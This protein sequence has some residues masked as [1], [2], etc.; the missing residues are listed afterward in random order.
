[1]QG[2][3]V[4]LFATGAVA[5]E[6]GEVWIDAVALETQTGEIPE[7]TVSIPFTTQAVAVLEWV[8][9]AGAVYQPWASANLQAWTPLP[10]VIGSGGV[11]TAAEPLTE[12]RVFFRLGYP[13]QSTPDPDATLVPLFHATTEREPEVLEDTGTALVT[14]LADRARDRHAREDI[15]NGAVFRSYD[16]YLPFYWEQR[17]AEIEIEDRVAKGGDGVTFRFMTHAQ[18]NPAEFR[19]FYGNTPSV[20]LY[21]TNLSDLPGQG[22]TLTE[23]RPSTRY[24][25]ETE[26]HYEATLDTQAPEGRPLEVGDRIEIELSQFLLSPRNGRPNYYGTAFLYVVGQGVVPW[27]AKFREEAPDPAAREA[28]SFDSHPLPEKAWLGGRTTLPY[29]YSNEPTHRFKQMAGN[30]APINGREFMFGRRLHHTDF[31]DGSHSEPGNPVFS[32]QMGKAGPRF[33]ATRCVDCHVNNGR[34]MPPA[35]GTALGHHAVVHVGRN[36]EGA[37]DAFLGD[38]LQPQSTEGR[39]EPTAVLDSYEEQ[40]GHYGDGTPYTLRRPAYTFDGDTAPDFYSVRIAP[41]LVGLGLLEAIDEATLLALADPDDQDGDGISGRASIIRDPEDPARHRLGRFG[42]KAAQARLVHQVAAALNRDMGIATDL[43]P[44]LDGETLPAASELTAGELGQLTRYVALLGVGAR[45]N[46]TDADALRGEVV[47]EA[48]GC[49]KCHTPALTTGAHHPLA[50]LRNQTIHPYSDLLLHDL[51]AGLADGMGENG[52]SGAEWRTA[53]LWNI[54]LTRGVGDGNEAYLHDGRA[55]TLE[56][57]ILWHGREAA[58]ASEQFRT[59]SAA[60]RNALI[61]FLES[62]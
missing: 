44:F 17:V 19:A 9:E 36:A 3:L 18:L 62:L 24:S 39:V 2:R 52:A 42:A 32:E 51:G 50:E 58:Q 29:R 15:V 54:G 1:V 31:S 48:I 38:H 6:I 7:S 35:V 47:F 8:S 23:T 60:D 57:A 27:Y 12:G 25:G 33:I 26:Y 11:V 43:M 28:A 30:I 16:H 5:G 13:I 59:L 40:S 37:P 41:P 61:R 34:S 21:H 10:P 45:R 53:P 4:F 49:A 56:E 14:R 20:A 22:V 55:R 46:L